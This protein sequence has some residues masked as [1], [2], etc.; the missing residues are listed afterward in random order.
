VVLRAK[1]Q[2]YITNP[3]TRRLVFPVKRGKVDAP[4]VIAAGPQS[5]AADM[6]LVAIIRAYRAGLKVRWTVH[7]ELGISM[8]G[9]EDAEI[10]RQAMEEPFDQLHGFWCPVDVGVGANW[11]EAKND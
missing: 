4:K 7:D 11:L 3:F 9:P 8:R 1:K 2:G 10:L 5:T 6:M